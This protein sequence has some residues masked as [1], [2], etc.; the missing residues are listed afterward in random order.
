MSA[1]SQDH[2]RGELAR[3][4]RLG[5]AAGGE[6]GRA[7]SAFVVVE[8][9][10]PAAFVDGAIRFTAGLDPALAEAWLGTFTRAVFLAGDPLR[11][12]ARHPARQVAADGSAAWFGPAVADSLR[13]LRL[14]LKAF[15]APQLPPLPDRVELGDPRAD[16]RRL[17]YVA[18]AGIGTA[19][20]LVHLNHV[21]CEATIA[22]LLAP[23]TALEL[24]HVERIEDSRGSFACSRVVADEDGELRRCAAVAWEGAG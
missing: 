20:Y 6:E 15:E 2:L 12:A 14:L 18:T 8:R 11:I 13:G 5:A 17:L 24:R 22:G 16:E 9:V 23:G 1:V 21:V 3:R 19:E 4:L 10:E 7:L